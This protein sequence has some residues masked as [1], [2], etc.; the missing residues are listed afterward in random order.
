MEE[1]FNMKL[2][3]IK[4]QRREDELIYEKNL[5]KISKEHENYL[6]DF[7]DK[8]KIQEKEFKTKIEKLNKNFQI[9]KLE[10]DYN[11]GKLK[12]R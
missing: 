6:K 12:N 1:D 4:E 10:K 2:N 7:N 11:L 8:L 5:T 9:N 3:Q